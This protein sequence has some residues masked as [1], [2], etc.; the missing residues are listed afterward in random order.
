M[1]NILSMALMVTLYSIFL[2]AVFTAPL[3]A[4]G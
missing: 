1:K 2:M 3:W 4:R